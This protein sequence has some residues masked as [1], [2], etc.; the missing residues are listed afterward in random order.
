MRVRVRIIFLFSLVLNVALG[1]ALI[2]WLASAPENKPRVVR[3]FSAASLNSN[4]IRFISKTNILIRPRAFSWQEVESPDYAVYVENL[5]A[6]GM[7][8]TT[9]RDII[10]ADV[11]Q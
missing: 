10:V 1:V 7:P 6:L 5:R 2:T 8:D 3:P 4:G 11:D 9:V